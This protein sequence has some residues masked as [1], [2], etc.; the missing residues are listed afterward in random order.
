MKTKMGIGPRYDT[1]I[2]REKRWLQKRKK[3]SFPVLSAGG[4]ESAHGY[5]YEASRW[6]MQW[7]VQW[8]VLRQPG[9][10]EPSVWEILKTKSFIASPRLFVEYALSV[11]VDIRVDQGTQRQR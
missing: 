11:A 10:S 4:K 8:G 1:S 9:F 5:V 3:A 7:G 2:S 6:H